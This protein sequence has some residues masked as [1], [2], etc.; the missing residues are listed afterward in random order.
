[1][2]FRA[3]LCKSGAVSCWADRVA[4]F[5]TETTGLDPASARIVTAFVGL[6]DAAGALERGATWLADPGVEIPAAAAAVHGI[7][8]EVARRDGAPAAEVV[9][10]VAASI[11]W[12]AAQQLPLVVYNAPYDLTLLAAE[13]RRYGVTM[14]EVAPLVVDPLVIDKQLDRYRR[15][16]RI[17]EA[18]AAAYGVVLEDAHTAEADSLAAGRLAQAL[19]RAYPTELDVPLPDLYDAQAR[20]FDEQAADFEA[21]MRNRRGEAS[22]TAARGWPLRAS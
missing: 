12:V 18:V 19:V 15:G 2:Q 16:K 22:F 21:Y 11:A 10:K 6:V 3:A 20:W 7:T 9:G 5:D 13:C 17:L 4:V 8:T 1:M 14:P